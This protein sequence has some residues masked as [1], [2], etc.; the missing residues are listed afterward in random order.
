MPV[1]YD[2]TRGPGKVPGWRK[3]SS[4]RRP[5]CEKVNIWLT[6]HASPMS[7]GMGDSFEVPEAWRINGKWFHIHK[8]REMVEET[9]GLPVDTA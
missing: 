8:G 2:D 7:M 9:Y 6:I 5:D 1:S 3:V 4:F